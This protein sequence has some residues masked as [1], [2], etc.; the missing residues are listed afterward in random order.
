MKKNNRKPPSK[1]YGV[2]NYIYK[3][4]FSLVFFPKAHLQVEQKNK[5]VAVH[6]SSHRGGIQL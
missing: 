6:G 5:P 4:T 2:N 3:A 1:G